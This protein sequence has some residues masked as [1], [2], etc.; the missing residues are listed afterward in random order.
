MISL[1]AERNEDGKSR[2]LGPVAA[3][4][5]AQ[6]QRLIS[7]GESRSFLD[8]SSSANTLFRKKFDRDFRG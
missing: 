1:S 4:A 6:P 8:E 3:W 2:H 5:G 7:G